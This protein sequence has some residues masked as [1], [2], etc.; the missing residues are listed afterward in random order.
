MLKK[1]NEFLC[2]KYSALVENVGKLFDWQ[3]A[4]E[5]QMDYEN[6]TKDV[7]DMKKKMKEIEE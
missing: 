2:K 5:H 4:K 6:S 7:E 1:Q 3:D